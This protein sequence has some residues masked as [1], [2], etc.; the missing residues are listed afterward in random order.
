[1]Y[2]FVFPIRTITTIIP[3]RTILML[4]EREKDWANQDPAR[5]KTHS[6][7]GAGDGVDLV[8]HRDLAH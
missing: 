6:L 8:T 7:K 2:R 3:F 4:G 5:R 1:M